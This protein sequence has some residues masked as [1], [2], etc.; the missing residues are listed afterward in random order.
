MEP[1]IVEKRSNRMV[2]RS[3]NKKTGHGH[4]FDAEAIAFD[5]NEQT[6]DL[7]RKTHPTSRCGRVQAEA[8]RE[9]LKIQ[10]WA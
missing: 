4:E 1:M 8:A 5:P 7:R 6:A 3:L 10:D 9:F 2:Y